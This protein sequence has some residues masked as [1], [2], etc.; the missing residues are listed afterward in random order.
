MGNLFCSEYTIHRRFDLKGSSLGR[1]TDKPETELDANTILKDLDLNFLF[2]LQKTWFQEF[3]RF[4]VGFVS[5]FFLV[6]IILS[7]C[8]SRSNRLILH[9][10]C[11]WNSMLLYQAN[12]Q[13]L[14][15]SWTREDYGLQPSSW[16]SLQRTKHCCWSYSTGSS[17]TY[18]FL[19]FITLSNLKFQLLLTLWPVL[20]CLFFCVADG[21]SDTDSVPRLST[22]DMDRLLL[23]P[24]GYIYFI[25]CYFVI[26]MHGLS[27]NVCYKW[28]WQVG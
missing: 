4:A 7:S 3:R 2:R 18:W 10:A 25:I 27:A 8:S 11:K 15:L 24:A 14:W 6:F 17:N 20:K 9:F 28:D 23:D 13:G 21:D 5:F 1:S 19:I 16:T 22:A 26:R 12:W